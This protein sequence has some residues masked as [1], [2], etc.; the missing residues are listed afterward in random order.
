MAQNVPPQGLAPG[1]GVEHFLEQFE[2]IVTPIADAS[3]DYFGWNF[4]EITF[5]MGVCTIISSAVGYIF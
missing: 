4:V 5:V 3:F 2:L 1:Q